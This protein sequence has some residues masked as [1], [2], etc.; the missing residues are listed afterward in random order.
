MLESGV[1]GQDGVV[2]LDDRARKLWW[3]VQNKLEFRLLAIVH[4]EAL[5]KE[6]TETR[7][8]STA[9]GVEDEES[10]ES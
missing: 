9:E 10:L 6:S 3:G 5:Q 4:G 8:S 1:G 7:T 2:W